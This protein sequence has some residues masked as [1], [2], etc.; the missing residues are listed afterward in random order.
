VIRR[1]GSPVPDTTQ[2]LEEGVE[3]CP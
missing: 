1:H 2:G 3:N